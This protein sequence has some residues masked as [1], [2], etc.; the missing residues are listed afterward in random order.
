MITKK[1]KSKKKGDNF[2][3]KIGD[4][5]TIENELKDREL[6]LYNEFTG[7]KLTNYLLSDENHMIALCGGTDRYTKIKKAIQDIPNYEKRVFVCTSNSNI[8]LIKQLSS[9]LIGDTDLDIRVKTTSGYNRKTTSGYKPTTKLDIIQ[10]WIDFTDRYPNYRWPPDYAS[11][12]VRILSSNEGKSLP[13]PR[14]RV[15]EREMEG[16][17]FDQ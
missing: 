12:A 3:Q 4:Q 13:E 5:I 10:D 7:Y 15:S 16:R 1:T 17:L 9:H 2:K 14:A 6:A 11:P 8:K